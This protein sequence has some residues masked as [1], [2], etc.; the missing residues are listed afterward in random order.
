MLVVETDKGDEMPIEMTP[1]QRRKSLFAK[2][3][4]G[5]YFH[6]EEYCIDEDAENGEFFWDIKKV[7][8]VDACPVDYN[9]YKMNANNTI[10]TK[11]DETTEKDTMNNSIT[12]NGVVLTVEGISNQAYE[13]STH[14][15]ENG[16]H[17]HFEIP[18]PKTD[19]GTFEIS[20]DHFENDHY[21]MND[22]AAI[23]TNIEEPTKNDTKKNSSIKE[24][25]VLNVEGLNHEAYE[26]STDNLANLQFEIHGPKMNDENF[27]ISIDDS[28]NPHFLQF[29]M[30]KTKANNKDYEIST[31]N[32]L[33]SHYQ[34][35]EIPKPKVSNGDVKER[36]EDIT[37]NKKTD[38]NGI[39][40]K[41]TNDDKRKIRI[42][43]KR[44]TKV[45][46]SI[47]D[48]LK[49]LYTNVSFVLLMISLAMF[50]FG[51][52]VV[53]THILP[54]AVSENISSSVQ[55]LLVSILRCSAFVGKLALGA[56]NQSP[57]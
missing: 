11:I 49:M 12:G 48:K 18:E 40:T 16:H 8:S 19:N 52:S 39:N 6:N 7:V 32:S 4:S 57:S 28:K 17:I 30:T 41:S 42:K 43:A 25:V 46:K 29:E 44:E 23:T 51:T 10:T 24:G 34:K 20:T 55:L 53:F 14:N 31:D 21:E 1:Q 33:N 22:N 5:Y 26:N 36:K 47:K 38:Q 2:S 35:F 54:Y 9:D 45:R 37:N 3:W 13:S 56:I 15:L 27:E 50:L